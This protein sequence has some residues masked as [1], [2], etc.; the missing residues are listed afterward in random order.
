M[1]IYI[2]GPITGRHT[3]N[4]EAFAEAERL[5]T[6]AGHEAVNPHTINADL[7]ENAPWETYLKRDIAELTTCDGIFNL[8]GWEGSKGARLENRV[9]HA[10]F[11]PVVVLAHRPTVVASDRDA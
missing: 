3:L 2:S 1:K 4:R 7:G 10:L 11:I 5:L 6:E 9:A 8:G